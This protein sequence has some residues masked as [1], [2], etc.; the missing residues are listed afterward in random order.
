MLKNIFYIV[1][2]IKGIKSIAKGVFL[3]IAALSG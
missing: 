1:Y 3:L 2:I